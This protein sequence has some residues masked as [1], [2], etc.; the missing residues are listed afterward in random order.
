MKPR[1][2]LC[3]LLCSAIILGISSPVAYASSEYSIDLS[4]IY[5]GTNYVVYYCE[6]ISF[7]YAVYV[8]TST[9]VGSFSI[10]QS[11]SPDYMYD[12]TFTISPED[13]IVNSL[14][15]WNTIIDHCFTVYSEYTPIYLPSA[16]VITTPENTTMLAVDPYEDDFY[17]LLDKRLEEKLYN[18]YDSELNYIKPYSNRGIYTASNQGTL[19][20]L[21]ETLNYYIDRDNS[22]YI[23]TAMTIAGFVVTIMGL[24]ASPPIL[25][26]IGVICGVDGILQSGTYIYEY[27]V[28]ALWRRN[29][30]LQNS[31]IN[32]TNYTKEIRYQGF[33]N[34]VTND[35]TLHYDGE[36]IT[37]S[38]L[39]DDI[40]AQFEEAFLS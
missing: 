15:F 5:Q 27:D 37:I 31:T 38:T 22:Y 9:G 19:Y 23:H 24:S 11:E 6:T 32:L 21:Y 18:N 7:R 36:K 12:L 13:I 20:M 3:I 25:G 8:N 28:Y 4:N 35:C 14:S 16:I 34:S 26:I 17:D 39:Y 29:V 40:D 33:A 30:R 1:K 2:F 10:I